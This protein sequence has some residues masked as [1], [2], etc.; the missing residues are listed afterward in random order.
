M[1]YDKGVLLVNLGTPN[2]PR[3]SD[4]HRY[5]T[6]F[7]TDK[8]VIDI[9]WLRRQMLVRGLIIPSRIKQSAASYAKIW[10]EQGSPLLTH[11]LD[12]QKKLQ[13]SAGEDYVV[14][15]AMRYQNPS[16]EKG[17]EA[18]LAHK[19]SKLLIL[20]LFPQYASATTGTVYEKVMQVLR[21]RTNVPELLFAG[22]FP[23]HPLMIDAFAS[24]AEP[25]DPASY[26]H[27][28]FSFHGLPER[29]LIKADE[30]GQRCLRTKEC[31]QKI[32]STNRNCYSAQCHATAQA[33]VN[34]LRIPKEK[35]TIAFQSRLGK[36]PWLQP[37]TQEVMLELLRQGKKN[38]LVFSPSF[39][40]DCLE[41][42]FEIGM[43]YKQ[44]F[45]HAG[46]E[47]LD[48]VPGLNST[49]AWIITLAAICQ[50]YFNITS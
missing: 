30:S 40:C 6:E 49:P 19:L 42:T 33:I 25:L 36:E 48:L 44:E 10:T 14:E 3:I 28:L 38:L 45:L 13:Q 50:S 23:T 22:S 16:I 47:R 12:C 29:Q 15:V 34:R 41:T 43:E 21:K 8:R 24:N 9:P 7:L 18:L 11:A 2:S 5:L 27:I 26:D 37:S 4:V 39:V 35:Y 32:C 20:P 17:L 31:C 46:G 1:A